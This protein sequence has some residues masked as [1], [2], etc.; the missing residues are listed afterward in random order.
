[1]NEP[2]QRRMR[3]RWVQLELALGEQQSLASDIYLVCAVC[4]PQRWRVAFDDMGKL[5]EAH[6]E[7]REICPHFVLAFRE[8]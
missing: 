8:I 2:R 4:G 5:L 3:G 6:S 7:A 1:M